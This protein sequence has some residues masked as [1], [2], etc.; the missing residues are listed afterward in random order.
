[1]FCT[2]QC[3]LLKIDTHIWYFKDRQKVYTVQMKFAMKPEVKILLEQISVH[4]NNF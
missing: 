4:Y 3:V 2:L 1:M